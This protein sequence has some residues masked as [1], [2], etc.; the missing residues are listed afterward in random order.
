LLGFVFWLDRQARSEQVTQL[1][2]LARDGHIMQ[3][4]HQLLCDHDLAFCSG[5]YLYA[6]R[7]AF[8]VPALT[9]I[10]ERTCDFLVSGTT[11]MPVGA[12]LSRIGL[13]VLESLPMILAAGFSGPEQMVLS[14]EDYGRLRALFYTLAPNLLLQAHAERSLLS[15]YLQQEDVHNQS[16]IGLVDIGW[17]G[18]LQESFCKLLSLSGQNKSQV[19]SGYISCR[20][21]SDSGRLP[22]AC[23]PV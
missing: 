12:F 9:E 17:H 11:R 10:N 13:S 6:S 7:R 2:F 5:R 23:I 14:G 16:H 1:Y 20:Y 15:E 21:G 19:L 3:A 18:S 4:A 8:N 22:S